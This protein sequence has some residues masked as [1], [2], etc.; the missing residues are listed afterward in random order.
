MKVLFVHNYYQQPGGEDQV[1]TT[2]AALLEAHGHRVVRYTVHNDK[3]A[4]M[5]PLSLVQATVWNKAV[6]RDLRALICRERPQVAHFHNTFPLISPAAYYA[7]KAEGVPVVQTLHNYRLLCPNGVF[8]RDGLLCEDC[9]GKAVPWPGVVHAC[10]R[11]SRAGTGVVATMLTLQRVLRIPT[12][13]VNLYIALTEFA[14][15]KFIQ[16][17]LPAE[18]IVVKPNFVDPDPGLGEGLGGYALFVGRLSPEKGIDTMLAAWE[19]LGRKVSL[20]I[21]GDGPLAVQVDKAARQLPG[22]EWLGRLSKT[23]V[24]AL[25]KDAHVLLFPSL[26]YEG[27]PMVLAE[28]GA[29]GLP[30]VASELGS[31]LS[32]ITPGHTGLHFHPGNPEDLAKQVEWAFTHP[33]ELTQIR[34]KARAEFESKYSAEQNYRILMEIYQTT[35]ANTIT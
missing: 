23:Q 33:A 10:Y 1:F 21:V 25:M 15:E 5:N 6:Y 22:V 7:A 29:V 4:E 30:V 35:G 13:V 3:V 17:G 24:I 11:S 19:R 32:L 27:F 2:E 12:E 16:A 34:R 26:W 9:L 31:M 18:K 28:A 8:F 20:K 14:R